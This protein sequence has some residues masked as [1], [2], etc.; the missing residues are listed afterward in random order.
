MADSQKVISHLF[1][2]G[3]GRKILCVLCG[4]DFELVDHLFLK[5]IY[6]RFV[7]WTTLPNLDCEDPDYDVIRIWK[8]RLARDGFGLLKRNFIGQVSILWVIWAV[9]NKVIFQHSGTD[10]LSAMSWAKSLI[11]D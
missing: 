1:L 4:T 11:T 3:G 7:T 5:C 10:P 2:E 6:T 9:R 8:L